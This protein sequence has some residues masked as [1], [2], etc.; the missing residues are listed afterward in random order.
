VECSKKRCA[1]LVLENISKKG[2]FPQC[3]KRDFF[4]SFKFSETFGEIE[5]PCKLG[6]K[7]PFTQDYYH[8]KRYHENGFIN[9]TTAN[10]EVEFKYHFFNNSFNA[11]IFLFP[12][13]ESNKTRTKIVLTT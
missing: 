4:Q 13:G 11:F 1:L 3:V 5:I 9:L 8:G 6:Y 7:W 10:G 12:F 2:E